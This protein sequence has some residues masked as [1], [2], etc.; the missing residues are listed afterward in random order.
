MRD[1]LE[2]AV[3]NPEADFIEIRFLEVWSSDIV[4]KGGQVYSVK[5]GDSLGL[6]VRALKDRSWGFASSNNLEKLG[7]AVKAAIKFARAS[8]K[9]SIDARLA[10]TP[11]MQDTIKTKPKKHPEDVSLEEKVGRCKELEKAGKISGKILTTDVGYMDA[12]SKYYYLNSDGTS[13]LYEPVKSY[14]SFTAYSRKKN[15]EVFSAKD[16]D[17]GI[18][19]VEILDKKEDFVRN[20][21]KKAL[22]LLDAKLPPSGEF[23]VVIDQRMAGVLAHEAIGH[24]CEGDAVITKNSILHGK[25]GSR[26]GSEYVTI[27]DDATLGDYFG[28]YPF[29][30][31]GTPAQRKVLIENGIL[32]RFLHSRETAAKAGEDY[33]GNAR[34]QG[35]ENFPLVRMSNTFF[36]KGDWKFEEML[37]DVDHGIYVSGTK[38]GV[39]DISTGYFQFAA[40]YGRLI[41]K[42]ELT[43]FLRDVTLI[44]NVLETL[45]HVDAATEKIKLGNPGLCGKANQMVPVSD[46]GPRMRIQNALVGGR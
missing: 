37:E 8:G 45:K 42:G 2:K 41:E 36:E 38:G 3:Q 10:E 23:P 5:S 39:C 1:I 26:L 30:D 33:T 4:L 21:S 20:V 11:L 16:S 27:V 32:R 43:T 22:K 17:A 13:L 29:D 46:G 12:V 18:K 40:L 24:A 28:T 25:L 14:F 34:A 6:S 7:D 15:G 44:G 9:R 19:G 31:E 35:V